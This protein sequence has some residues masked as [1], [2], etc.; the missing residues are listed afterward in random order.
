[1]KQLGRRDMGFDQAKQGMKYDPPALATSIV[2]AVALAIGTALMTVNEIVLPACLCYLCWRAQDTSRRVLF[3]D[4]RYRAAVAGDS[5]SHVGSL[6]T[7]NRHSLAEPPGV[8][9]HYSAH[10]PFPP[11]NGVTIAQDAVHGSAQP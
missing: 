1:M 6:P 3:A 2:L 8:C 9:C 4:F 11:I 7:R 5:V 10:A